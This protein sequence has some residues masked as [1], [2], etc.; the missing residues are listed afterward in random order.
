[1]GRRW[2]AE[3]RSTPSPV[4][5]SST[6]KSGALS[7]TSSAPAMSRPVDLVRSQSDPEGAW[8]MAE[9][10]ESGTVRAARRVQWR[11]AQT[12]AVL[13]GAVG[14]PTVRCIPAE[15]LSASRS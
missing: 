1:V 5:T 14:V 15:D 3:R 9:T 11:G 6:S 13:G 7:P 4:R 8:Y 12:C 2:S 10:V